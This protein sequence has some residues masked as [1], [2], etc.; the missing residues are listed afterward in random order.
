MKDSQ[1]MPAPTF[2]AVVT[3]SAA[4]RHRLARVLATATPEEALVVWTA[5]QQFI[6]NAEE[7]EDFE[8]PTADE[9]AAQSLMDRLDAAV[10]SLAG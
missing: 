2:P 8:P 9:V 3:T 10:A 7:R 5:L 1:T 6:D 4:E